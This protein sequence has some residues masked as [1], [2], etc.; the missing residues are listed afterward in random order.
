MHLR[1]L[2]PRSAADVVRRARARLRRQSA[3]P[4]ER[5]R[6]PSFSCY[7][8]KRWEEAVDALDLERERPLQL[9]NTDGEPLLL[10]TDHLA[11]EATQR[12]AVAQRLGALEGVELPEEGEGIYTFLRPGNRMHK[13]WENTVVGRAV[14]G[15]GELRLE[16]NSVRRAD[17]LRRRI[18]AACAGLLRFR[19]REH[20]DPTALLGAKEP[21]GAPVETDD[22]PEQ[23]GLLRELKQRSYAD[24]LDEPLPAL[25][26]KTPR[27]AV[28]SRAGREQ[29]D[30]LLRDIENLE[31]RQ[32]PGQ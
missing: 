7:L 19:G 13:S 12:G 30:V 28:R 26:G 2:P 17:E 16:S 31:S 20:T 6:D 1:P 23:Q 11:F 8:I 9:Q 27:Q 24:W 32:P 21:E 29:V 25:G 14:L 5:L 10:T 3:V 4:V 15:E 22:S 18:E